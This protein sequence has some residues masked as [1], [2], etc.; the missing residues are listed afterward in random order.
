MYNVNH[1]KLD[2]PLSN[3]ALVEFLFNTFNSAI[4]SFFFFITMIKSEGQPSFLH[5]RL[6]TK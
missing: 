5:H 2:V 3:S 4:P 1:N 6:K